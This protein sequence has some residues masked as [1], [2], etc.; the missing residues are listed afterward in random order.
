MSSFKFEDITL[1][2][3]LFKQVLA[4]H[5][6]MSKKKY[7]LYKLVLLCVHIRQQHEETQL[8]SEGCVLPVSADV[9]K[10]LLEGLSMIYSEYKTHSI[11]IEFLMKVLMKSFQYFNYL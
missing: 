4:I 1:N 7:F 8:D 2:Y 3:Q 5:M 10:K 6:L 11:W 9:Q